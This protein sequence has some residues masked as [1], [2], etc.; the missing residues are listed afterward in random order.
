MMPLSDGNQQEPYGEKT[1][2]LLPFPR[3]TTSDSL[4]DD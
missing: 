1:I 2:R 3:E 4:E